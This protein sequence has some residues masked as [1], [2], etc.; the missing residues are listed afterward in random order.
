M[1]IL[2]NMSEGLKKNSADYVSPN[3]RLLQ[4]NE[5][6]FPKWLLAT[7]AAVWFLIFACIPRPANAFTPFRIGTGG[8]T[9]VYYP[10]GRLIAL[11]IT[12]IV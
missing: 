11:G 4:V 8:E 10:V 5:D 6:F 1:R 3:S 9:G 7:L 12:L 2:T